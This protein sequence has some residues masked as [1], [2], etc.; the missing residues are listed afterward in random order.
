MDIKEI[1]REQYGRIAA[2]EPGACGCCDSGQV[3]LDLGYQEADLEGVPEEANLGL[4]CGNPTAIAALGPGET[5]VDLGS[6]AGIDCFLAARRVGPAGRVI[7]IDMTDA[8]L[9]RARASA[10][11]G[12][13]VNVEFRKGDVEALPLEDASVDVILSN[14]VLNLVPDKRQA[15]AEIAR[16]LRPGGRIAVSDIVLERPLP[17]ALGSDPAAYAV[18]ISGAIPRSDYLRLLEEAGLADVRVTQAVDAAEML[19]ESEGPVSDAARGCCGPGELRGVI[20]S[21]HVTARR[22]G[23]AA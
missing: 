11:R 8:M 5:V 2:G 14:C 7:G 13:F 18:C 1:V 15:F 17:E 16:V 22:P 6:G 23:D 3:A 4:G 10:E 12:G 21:I 20:S 9:D 19:L